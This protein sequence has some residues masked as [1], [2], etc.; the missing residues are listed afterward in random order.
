MLPD[1]V[2]ET[3]TDIWRLFYVIIGVNSPVHCIRH[4][5]NKLTTQEACSEDRENSTKVFKKVL[6]HDQLHCSSWRSSHPQK[7][8]W[9]SLL[10]H[11]KCCFASFK[12][13]QDWVKSDFGTC[14]K[15]KAFFMMSPPLSSRVVL[16]RHIDKTSWHALPIN[17][18][19]RAAAKYVLYRVN[20][21]KSNFSKKNMTRPAVTKV[22]QAVFDDTW[23]KH[24]RPQK[25]QLDPAFV[26][27]LNFP[28]S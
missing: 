20:E 12:L 8:G 18:S 3:S 15:R 21:W 28:T 9:I 11:W 23:Y 19:P 10:W 16:W 25:I 7:K 2:S 27:P 1:A 6:S 4:C 14:E 26:P 24:C 13:Q 5:F 22:C 17:F